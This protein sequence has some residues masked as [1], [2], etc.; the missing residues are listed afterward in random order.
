MRP[1]EESVSA[2]M[3]SRI[4]LKNQKSLATNE[5]ESLIQDLP[6]LRLSEEDSVGYSSS[7]DKEDYIPSLN[8]KP[9]GSEPRKNL[10]TAV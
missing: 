6:S 7:V 1:A 4:K 10:E 8:D 2:V 3:S 9:G 5:V